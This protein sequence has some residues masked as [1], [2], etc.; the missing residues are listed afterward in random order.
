MGRKPSELSVDELIIRAWQS[1]E[2]EHAAGWPRA[3]RWLRHLSAEVGEELR[4][5]GFDVELANE[6]DHR[7]AEVDGHADDW[8]IFLDGDL[9]RRVIGALSSP[10]QSERITKVIGI[11]ARGFLLGGAVALELGAGFVAVRKSG[12]LPG[13]KLTQRTSRADYRGLTHELRLQAGALGRRD[14]VLLVDDWIEM[15]SQSAA[16]KSL[17]DQARAAFVGTSVIVN[18]L[19][20]DRAG[21]FGKLRYLVRYF[22][23]DDQ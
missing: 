18:Q 21:E 17:V 15:G 23:H 8:R 10:F 22:P 6:V 13:A 12:H 14:R 4:R 16:A 20:A 11:E 9:F 2:R 19:P 5:R 7:I 1:E 3:R